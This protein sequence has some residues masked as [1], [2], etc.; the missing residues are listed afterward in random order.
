MV[1]RKGGKVRRG[2][3]KENRRKRSGEVRRRKWDVARREGAKGRLRSGTDKRMGRR[4][5]GKSKR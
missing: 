1:G 3:G 4:E 5:G 2:G